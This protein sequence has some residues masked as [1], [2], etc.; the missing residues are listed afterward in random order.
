MQ[1]PNRKIAKALPAEDESGAYLGISIGSSYYS[2]QRIR[3]YLAY[4]NAVFS[5]FAFLIGD[6]IY[7][8]TLA[9]TKDI[10]LEEA[11][12]RAHMIGDE[13]E[14]MLKN[15]IEMSGH[16]A[17]VLRWSDVENMPEYN[18]LLHVVTETYNTNKQFKKL[19]RKQIFLN[20]GGRVAEAG[21]SQDPR[22]DNDISNLFDT[23]I[24]EEIAGLITV[25][26][27]T[28]YH[29][30]IYP[31]KDLIILKKIYQDRFQK[32]SDALPTIRKRQFK[33]LKIN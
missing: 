1:T 9:G 23:Y 5:H 32:I 30:E 8:F 12:R 16:A 6:G 7:K 28:Q 25:S 29:L 11:T 15:I 2:K 4:A 13:R 20:L 10:S 19:V 27:F 31:G 3:H 24:L 14:R 33:Q 17:K 22:F 18:S 26:E 21:L